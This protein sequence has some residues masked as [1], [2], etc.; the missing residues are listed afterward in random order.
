MKKV[1]SS[2]LLILICNLF[3]INFGYAQLEPF[4]LPGKKINAISLFSNFNIP[5]QYYLYA[6]SDSNGVF[7]R[8]LSSSDSV[9]VNHG[10]AGKKITSL[11]I[12]NWGP[13]NIYSIFAGVRPNKFSGDSTLIY[14]RSYSGN[15]SSADSGLNANTIDQINAIGGFF[16]TGHAPPEPIFA[17]NGSGIYRAIGFPPNLNWQKV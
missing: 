7:L 10:L 17:A 3:L 6:G 13:A 12:Y 8:E 15:W 16:F 2:D 9:W 1:F 14:E 11:H 5:S 4:G